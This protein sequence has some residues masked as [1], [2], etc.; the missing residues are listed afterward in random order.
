MTWVASRR[1][2]SEP[3]TKNALTS[4][5]WS[6][7]IAAARLA[8]ADR[9]DAREFFLQRLRRCGLRLRLV[10]A[11]RVEVA[12]LARL[13]VAGRGGVGFQDLAEE[14]EVPLDDLGE[15]PRPRRPLGWDGGLRR[16]AA[17]REFIEVGTGVDG[18]V[19]RVR[20]EARRKRSGRGR[21]GR[22]PAAED[23]RSEDQ[24][25]GD[26]HDAPAYRPPS[27]RST[28]RLVSSPAGMALGDR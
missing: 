28:A 4:R 5:R 3:K 22:R 23:R 6:R 14:R 20:V 10:H 19:E 18:G 7:A 25:H 24:D 9:R 11:R 15:A 2:C 26:A 27:R 16:P 13:A 1:S 17:A 12:E 21:R 8:V